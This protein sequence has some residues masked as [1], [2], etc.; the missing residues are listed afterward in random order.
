[1]NNNS[2]DEDEN[3]NQINNKV[4]FN[5]ENK[6]NNNILNLKIISSLN[7]D[8]KLAINTENKDMSI[9]S[10]DFTQS[11][12]RWW[13]SQSRTQ[14]ID[15][16]ESVIN[17]SF[18][19]TDTIFEEENNSDVEICDIKDNFKEEKSSILHRFLIDLTGVKR[20]L[21]NLKLTYN[22]DVKIISRINVLQ[23]RIGIRITK[24]NSVLVI[25]K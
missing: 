13:N 15:Q 25:K 19:I 12:R 17:E 22:D 1:M 20:G 9:E 6:V 16:I 23:E 11:I 7:K 3:Q 24:L 18:Q 4:N 21:D 2:D 14:S 10:N 5:I 8:D